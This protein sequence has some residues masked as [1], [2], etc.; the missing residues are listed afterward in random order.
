MLTISPWNTWPL[1]VKIYSDEAAKLW[2]AVD[3][4]APELPEGCS[5][6][7]E[8]EGVDGKSGQRGSGRTGPI[9]VTD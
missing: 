7:Y 9:D 2:A 4:D 6:S 3:V 1:R 5:V 8:F